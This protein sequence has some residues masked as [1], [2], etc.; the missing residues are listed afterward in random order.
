M[1]HVLAL[2]VAVSTALGGVA[3][4]AEAQKVSLNVYGVACAGCIKPLAAALV[5][6]GVQNASEITFIKGKESARVEGEIAE[7]ADL[8]EAA[9][10]VNVTD[11]P[12]KGTVAPGLSLVLFAELDGDLSAKALQALAEVKG[13][14]AEGSSADDEQSEISAKIKGDDR[15]TV[16]DILQALRDAGIE[17]STTTK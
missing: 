5:Q 6:G 14:D 3:L 1:K 4:A 9:E 13:V 8:R 10:A 15:V 16:A 11:T 12:C 7:D 2:T 17:A